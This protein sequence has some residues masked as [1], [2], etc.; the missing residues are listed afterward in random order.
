MKQI[1]VAGD[2]SLFRTNKFQCSHKK[3]HK[4]VFKPH[5]Q[6]LFLPRKFHLNPLSANPTRWSNTLK[7]FVGCCRRV[8]W[9]CLTVLW[10]WRLKKVKCLTGFY[11]LLCTIRVYLW[12]LPK[13]H[14]KVNLWT[15]FY[16]IRA[17]KTFFEVLRRSVKKI[18]TNFPGVEIL[19]EGTRANGLRFLGNDALRDLVIFLPF[20]KRGIHPWPK[21]GTLL[22]VAPPPPMGVFHVF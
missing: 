9:V 13:Y 21:P 18:K 14:C 15:N 22:K 20:K 6:K 17:F 19:H 12:K 11:M 8:V 1:V 3:Y 7:Q 5:F 16:M 10:G 4:G 2:F